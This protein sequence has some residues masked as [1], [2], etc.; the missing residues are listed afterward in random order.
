MQKFLICG[1]IIVDHFTCRNFV[2][3]YNYYVGGSDYEEI[4]G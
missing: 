3:L 4:H 2:L 1:N